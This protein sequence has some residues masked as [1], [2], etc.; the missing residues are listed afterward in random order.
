MNQPQLFPTSVPLVPPDTREQ[1]HNKVKPSKHSLR[2]ALLKDLYEGRWSAD[3]W[4][5][6]KGISILSVRPRMSELKKKGL[7]YRVGFGRTVDGNNQEKFTMFP[8]I[9]NRMQLVACKF[10][11]DKAAKEMLASFGL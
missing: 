6:S 9:R 8:Y 3:E 2:V 1:A 5:A 7:I 11:I 4:A 10:G